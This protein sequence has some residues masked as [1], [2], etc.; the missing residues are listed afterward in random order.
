MLTMPV[1]AFD[2]ALTASLL[3]DAELAALIDDRAMARAMVETERA[4][5]RVQG[6]LGVIP[7]QAA[8][9]IDAALDGLTPDLAALGAGTAGSGVPTIALVAALRDRLGDTARDHVHVGATSQ[10][11]LDTAL[12]LCLRR[13]LERLEARLDG[14]LRKLS[15]LADAHRR[16][17]MAG[18]TRS[19]QAVPISF[20]LKAAGWRA[21]LKRHRRRLAAV[22]EDL[23][24]VQFGG[25]AGTLAALGDAGVAVADALADELGLARADSPW[26]TA[27]D[28]LLG[29]GGWLS[30]VTASLGKIG[31]DLLLLSQSEVAEVKL[32]AGGGSSA[33]PQKVNPVG[34][35]MLVT[36]ARANATHLGG[37][38]HAAIQDHERGG[39]GWTLEW[40]T[41]PP[42][43]L[44]TAAALRITAETLAGLTVNADRMR[45][46]LGLDTGMILAEAATVAL[47]THLGRTRAQALVKQACT[48]APT[49]GRSILDLLAE[50]TEAAV[51]WAA[52]AA[53]ERYLGSADAII[54][55]VLKD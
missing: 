52:L 8:D 14:V 12:I 50:R 36:L 31:A 41:M 53:P 25:A 15:D 32:A 27:R 35:E 48:D 4:L 49:A 21:P 19:Q 5:A 7:P 40:V 20:G 3:S 28:G 9:A 55:R 30:G 51:D 1:T 37:L 34:A 45:A 23:L 39:P 26:H 16:T 6:R 11:I 33:M 44:A 47:A 54:D 18:R 29:L 46:N 22:R 24:V 38:H 43:I 17:V 42:M 13:A 10:D 2:S